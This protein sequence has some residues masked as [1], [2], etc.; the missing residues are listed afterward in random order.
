ML[1]TAAGRVIESM[2]K[3]ISLKRAVLAAVAL[4]AFGATA[5]FA[6]TAT[7]PA[8]T[9]ATTTTTGTDG[10]PHGGW[11]HHHHG[12]GVLNR[13]E[14][15]ELKKGPGHRSSRP[16]RRSRRRRKSLTSNSRRSRARTPPATQAQL[17]ALKQQHV[18]SR[19]KCAR[20]SR[21]STPAP[22]RSSRKLMRRRASIITG[23]SNQGGDASPLASHF[24]SQ[25]RAGDCRPYL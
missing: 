21:T 8:A 25:G 23:S 11:H 6:Q 14:R 22:L 15:A 5:A 9:D 16:T 17:E 19:R 18:P 1:P 13:T 24:S 12:F 10:Q 4:G 3:M 2:N 20:P 7:T